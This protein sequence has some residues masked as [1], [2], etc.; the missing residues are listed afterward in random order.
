MAQIVW[1]GMHF[2]LTNYAARANMGKGFMY[3]EDEKQTPSEIFH[4]SL[5][6]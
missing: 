6:M 4:Q 1:Q 3:E 5:I 2:I